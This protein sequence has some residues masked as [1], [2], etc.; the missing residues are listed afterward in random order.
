MVQTKPIWAGKRE[1]RPSEPGSQTTA[2]QTRRARQKSGFADLIL[3]IGP[4]TRVETRLGDFCRGCQTKPISRRCQRAKQSQSAS[5]G[6]RAKQS[7][8]ASAGYRAKQSQFTSA[9][10]NGP[11]RQ[12]R[13][14]APIG[15]SIVRNKPNFPDA[16]MVANCGSQRGLGEEYADTAS[17]KTKPI[18]RVHQRGRIPLRTNKANSHQGGEGR[19]GPSLAPR[20]S[21]SSPG[22]LQK[23]TQFP[24]VDIPHH[25]TIPSFQH[26]KPGPIV[27]NK[28][29]FPGRGRLPAGR[30]TRSIVRN[31]ANLSR[32]RV[33]ASALGKK[34]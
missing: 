26:S 15:G 22:V 27:R 29:N 30:P 13:E 31:K 18:S 7:Q 17:E 4:E 5:A 23:Q 28:A 25:S 2:A 20:P 12:G 33:W 8:S 14:Q 10:R 24:A 21:G 32:E 3:G 1:P 11:G 9:D 6:Y 16:E 34:D 19:S